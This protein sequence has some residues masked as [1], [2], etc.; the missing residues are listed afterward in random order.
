LVTTLFV[1]PS[2]YSLVV[3]DPKNILADKEIPGGDGAKREQES[4]SAE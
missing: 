3:R 2:L 1:V 4:P